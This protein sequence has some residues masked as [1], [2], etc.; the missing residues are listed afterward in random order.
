MAQRGAAMPDPSIIETI[1]RAE[2]ELNLIKQSLLDNGW[3]FILYRTSKEHGRSGIERAT[4]YLY[5][6]NRDCG[7][8]FTVT[9]GE[10]MLI[11]FRTIGEQMEGFVD[12]MSWLVTVRE[13]AKM[14]VHTCNRKIRHAELDRSTAERIANLELQ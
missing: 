11:T 4:L 2:Y 7:L 1:E 12:T 8:E 10:R 3:E 14:C 13:L 5:M 6:W 9:V